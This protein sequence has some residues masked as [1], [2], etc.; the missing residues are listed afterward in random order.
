MHPRHH[1]KGQDPAE[2]ALMPLTLAV[3]RQIQRQGTKLR[4]P[5]DAVTAVEVRSSCTKRAYL[6][7]CVIMRD[8]P[9]ERTD[10]EGREDPAHGD[11]VALR[12]KL[13]YPEDGVLFDEA[14]QCFEQGAYRA[15][16]VM[17]WLAIAEG[18]RYRFKVAAQ[19]DLELTSLLEQVER[20]E[21]E[22]HA[23]DS[24]L[25]DK[26]KKHEL[27]SDHEHKDLAHVRDQRNRYGH[28]SGASPSRTQAL[29]ALDAAVQI[30]L[31][32]PAQHR[33]E[34]TDALVRRAATDRT[35][36]PRDPDA[37][38]A[39]AREI[40]PLL[41]REA[42]RHLV[43][44]AVE[45]LDGL[46]TDPARSDLAGK[47]A[48]LA[49]AILAAHIELISAL[50]LADRLARRERAAAL[51]CLRPEVFD[52]L[53]S[54]LSGAVLASV[55]EPPQDA[56]AGWQPD[57]R[58]LIA[59]QDL[60]EAHPLP[61]LW[62]E[63]LDKHIAALPL[64]EL[65]GLEFP[66][67]PLATRLVEEMRSHNWNRQN[68]ACRAVAN[69]GPVWCSR[70]PEPVQEQLGRNVL[71]S[72]EGDAKDASW[73]LTRISFAADE[74]PRQ[75]VYGIAVECVVHEHGRLRLKAEARDKVEAI[76][77]VRHDGAEIVQ[78][79]CEAAMAPG[80]FGMELFLAELAP[81][82]QQRPSPMLRAVHDRLTGVPPAS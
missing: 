2:P 46:A 40:D 69:L 58:I 71:Q 80:A 47:V 11:L 44:A 70:L 7:S 64:N 20:L 63:Q 16:L 57:V 15:A 56:G 23:I 13:R 14:A 75:F 82:L 29:A 76:L 39:Y 38:R 6:P 43:L 78:A 19:R 4:H 24:F 1:T 52:R 60:H 36:F 68:Q 62:A 5:D 51:V 55:L 32:R 28:P 54:P 34:W 33:T 37:L 48:I 73:L 30:V 72:A 65:T 25:L 66:A 3:V 61:S 67:G 74:W 59:V 31:S 18:L 77:A 79:V 17:T 53:D 12:A 21:R 81:L 9:L 35:F 50:D 22:R 45:E 42:R 41:T 10:L 49:G 26:A 27:I 8:M